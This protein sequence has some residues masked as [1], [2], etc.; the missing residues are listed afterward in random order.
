MSSRR[1][2]VVGSALALAALAGCVSGN[3][4][5]D[6][7]T[8]EN[9][10]G[11]NGENGEANGDDDGSAQIPDMSEYTAWVPAE[12]G[13]EDEWFIGAFSPEAIAP[14]DDNFQEVT[15]ILGAEPE[16]IP[17]QLVIGSNV[18]GD[19]SEVLIYAGE[20]DPEAVVSGFEEVAPG[21]VS[22]GGPID[23]YERYD[24]ADDMLAVTED[25]VIIAFEEES[26]EF[27]IETVE[28]E[29]EPLVDADDRFERFEGR[30]DP[31]DIVMVDTSSDREELLLGVAY[32]VGEPES[33]VSVIVTG[34]DEDALD[35]ADEKLEAV[36]DEDDALDEFDIDW[37][38]ERD[39]S[40]L[41]LSGTHL[42]GTEYPSGLEAATLLFEFAE[43]AID[44]DAPPDDVTVPQVS[45]DYDYQAE[46]G[47]LTLTHQAGDTLTAS[48]VSFEGEQID[49]AGQTWA[50][51]A[52]IDSDETV[53]AGE[54]VTLT[55][56]SDDF[57]LDVIWTYE[58][59]ATV[60]SSQSG[61]GA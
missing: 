18:D 46:T 61:S 50:D 30:R 55:A 29:P 1:K 36:L 8:G 47:E 2:F 16:Q 31:A 5:D 24:S 51:V 37:T 33:R 42:I 25:V 10:D 19:G 59:I 56:E 49:E 23:G 13:N 32:E 43:R 34:D 57:V 27:G 17:L 35:V 6:G 14:Y 11:E 60:I 58:D 38:Y 26:I 7:E 12:I 54:R 45:F 20:F 28:S 44:P 3:S 41:H 4:D 9:G 21:A 40:V 15:G 48:E 22:E 52:D 39:E 53:T